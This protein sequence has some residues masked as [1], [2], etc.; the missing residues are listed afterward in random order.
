MVSYRIV[1]LLLQFLIFVNGRRPKNLRR[2]GIQALDFISSTQGQSFPSRCRFVDLF[3]QFCTDLHIGHFGRCHDS[4]GCE[5]WILGFFNFDGFGVGSCRVVFQFHWDG[6]WTFFGS[7]TENCKWKFVKW[8]MWR[9]RFWKCDFWE[10]LASKMWFLWKM[11]FWKCDFCEKWDFENV[12]FTK[13]AILEI[14]TSL[15][16]WFWTY[17]FLD[18]LRIFAPVLTVNVA[19][20]ARNV[21]CNFFCDFQTPFYIP[22]P[23]V[24]QW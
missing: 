16:M 12:N 19:R 2:I 24:I 15:N 10:K 9:M 1:I 3:V 8:F 14:W 23:C 11:R 13:N 5:R 17:Q 18:K 7:W 21:E 6:C 20:F 4:F 22:E